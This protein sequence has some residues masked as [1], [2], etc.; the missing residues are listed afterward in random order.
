MIVSITDSWIRTAKS[1]SKTWYRDKNTSYLFLRVNKIS[2][3]YS[4]SWNFRKMKDGKRYTSHFGMYPDMSVEEARILADTMHRKLVLGDINNDVTE[5]A[6]KPKYRNTVKLKNI[7]II[8]KSFGAMMD[9]YISLL[10]SNGRQSAQNVGQ[11]IRKHIMNKHRKVWEKKANRITSED[12]KVILNDK[13]LNSTPYVWDKVLTYMRTAFNKTIRAEFSYSPSDVLQGF[14]IDNNPTAK[15]QR[16]PS[17]HKKPLDRKYVL[18]Y[19]QFIRFGE[20]INKLPDKRWQLYA[21]LLVLLGG[22]RP[23]QLLRVRKEDVSLIAGQASITILDEKGNANSK[24]KY[25]VVPLTPKAVS[26]IQELKPFQ[27]GYLF[28]RIKRYRTADG[29]TTNY[30]RIIEADEFSTNIFKPIA[31]MMVKEGLWEGKLFTTN[32]LRKTGETYLSS[33][34]C[35]V[36]LETRNHFYSHGVSGLIYDAY[37]RNEFYEEKLECMKHFEKV[38]L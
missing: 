2:G 21:K 32:I 13:E 17:E 11:T 38:L 26:I 12:I 30:G 3:G 16:L 20:L 15:F 27:T 33:K 6:I 25:H 22:Q 9:G 14:D 24:A 34:R 31:K 29:E 28:E 35:K 19:D 5:L 7:R 1:K 23:L 4:K 36:P 10:E 37:N 18:Q 8:P